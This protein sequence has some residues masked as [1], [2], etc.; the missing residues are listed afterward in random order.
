MMECL[1]IADGSAEGVSESLVSYFGSFERNH[2]I[3]VR[4]AFLLIKTLL[5]LINDKEMLNSVL[6]SACSKLE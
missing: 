5:E 1:I 3:N 4:V 2:C 6:H